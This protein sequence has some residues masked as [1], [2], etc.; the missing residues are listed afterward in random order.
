MRPSNGLAHKL[1][2][3]VSELGPHKPERVPKCPWIPIS[4]VE[5]PWREWHRHETSPAR[6]AAR[7]QCLWPLEHAPQLF[8][9]VRLLKRESYGGAGPA[10]PLVVGSPAVGSLIVGSLIGNLFLESS[11]PSQT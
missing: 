10:D 9:F 11:S 1:S 3:H 5:G 2:R 7:R 6:L 4:A 8:G